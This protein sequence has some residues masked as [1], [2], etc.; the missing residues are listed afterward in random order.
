MENK[1]ELTT[2]DF[3]NCELPFCATRDDRAPLFTAEAYVNNEIT[4]ISLED[5]QQKW[6]VLFFYSSDFT[7]V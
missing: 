4:N 3:K 2:D 6:V 7:F 1:K 5:Y